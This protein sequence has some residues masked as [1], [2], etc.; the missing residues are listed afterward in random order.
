MN[1]NK[2]VYTEAFDRARTGKS[3]SMW[4]RLLDPFQDQYT[5][6][7]RAKGEH[8]GSAEHERTAEQQTA[9]A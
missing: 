6:Q 1:G 9:S 8:D 5:R 4:D 7:S 3:R 2:Q